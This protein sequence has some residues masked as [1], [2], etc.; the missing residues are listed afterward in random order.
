MVFSQVEKLFKMTNDPYLNKTWFTT[1][2][3]YL[4]LIHQPIYLVNYLPIYYPPT[5]PPI[6]YL[7]TYLPIPSHLPTYIPTSV[8]HLCTTYLL[9]YP[10]PYLPTYLH[11]IYLPI[12][13]FIYLI[14][15]ITCNHKV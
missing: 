3:I 12:H 1:L 7:L 13:P 8:F 4:F 5:H 9:T 14:L 2:C 11:I 15:A 10:L 6:I